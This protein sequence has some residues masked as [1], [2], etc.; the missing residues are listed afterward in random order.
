M[1]PFKKRG[2]ATAGLTIDPTNGDPQVR[3]LVAAVAARDSATIRAILDGAPDPDTHAYLMESAAEV[4]G[5]QDWI[6][7][8]IAAE[9]HSTLPTLLR[10][11]HGVFWA[12][13]AR[14]AARAEYTR[15]EQFREFHRRLRIAE[16]ALD[17]VVDRD[18]GN[19][20]AWT[21][22]VTS[23][24][25]R[26]VAPDEAA[27]RF[28]EVVKRHP[29]HVVAH[30]QHLQYL[31]AK[32]F[33][34]DEQMFAF[35]RQA[36]AAAPDGSLVP[37]VLVVAHIE[38]WLSLPRG[39]DDQ[40]LRSAPVRAD[41]L[42]AVHK[43]LFHPAFRPGLGWFPRANSFAMG[44]EK[45]GEFD[46]AARVFDMIGDQVT[47]WPWSYCGNVV[48]EFATARERAYANRVR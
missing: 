40:Y 45:A 23:A 10:G 38:K 20:T 6:G 19:V 46:A 16:N 5:V 22:L 15:E 25:G 36:T 48:K 41:M 12:W 17:E 1:W 18:P 42:A 21:W 34:S 3:A 44:L 31:C 27:A 47:D 39:E 33:G 8:W 35:A 32:W 7:G 9:P 30:E 4:D 37:E 28:A 43:S 2:P 24:R 26:Q 29:A 14:G 11:C 13:E